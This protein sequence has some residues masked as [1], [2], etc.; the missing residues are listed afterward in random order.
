DGPTWKASTG[1]L[2]NPS[3]FWSCIA[4]GAR[5][6]RTSRS[7]RCGSSHLPADGMDAAAAAVEDSAAMA[8]R[9][10]CSTFASFPGDEQPAATTVNASS[11]ARILS[12]MAREQVA[13]TASVRVDKWLWA[14]RF[15]KSR[16]IAVTAIEGGKVTV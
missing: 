7:T 5:P 14:A 13:A 12:A 1:T 11:V 2:Q 10:A 3:P 9:V 6:A 16:S 4:R 15:L 8:A